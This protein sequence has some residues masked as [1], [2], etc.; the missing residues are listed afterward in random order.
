MGGSAIDLGSVEEDLGYTGDEEDIINLG[1]D[2][3]GLSLFVI[4]EDQ[5]LANFTDADHAIA[6]LSV[7]NLIADSGTLTQTASG[8]EFIPSKD[9]VGYVNF[10]FSV[11]DGEASTPA[12]AK[13]AV[14]NVN[15]DLYDGRADPYITGGLEDEAI[16]I[17]REQLLDSIASDENWD[18]EQLSIS[19]INITAGDTW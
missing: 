6:E 9:F 4:T 2:A 14:T 12:T 10:S 3:F 7:V 19:D 13:L 11:T 5:L 17:S 8:W 15:D 1:T 16:A 18:S